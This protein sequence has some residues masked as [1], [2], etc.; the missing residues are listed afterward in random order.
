MRHPLLQIKQGAKGCGERHGGKW[1]NLAECAS[2]ISHHVLSFFTQIPRAPDNVCKPLSIYC[3]VFVIFY[4]N[5]RAQDYLLSQWV[6]PHVF[7]HFGYL[8]VF[9][10]YSIYF[11]SRVGYF[12]TDEETCL[13]I[14]LLWNIAECSG[15]QQTNWK[16]TNSICCF[17]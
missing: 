13:K 5:T 17:G 16:K 8:I 3:H 10:W 9:C 2:L 4:T 14:T 15:K 7:I 12:Q 6:L 11:Y 1:I